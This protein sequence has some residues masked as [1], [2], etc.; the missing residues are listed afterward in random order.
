MDNKKE[1][2]NNVNIYVN[3][4]VGKKPILFRLLIM[5]AIFVFICLLSLSLILIK[6]GVAYASENPY[7]YELI[8]KTDNPDK[9]F[10]FKGE[11]EN[12]YLVFNNLVWRIIRINSSGSIT[13]ML[14]ESLNRLPYS[15]GKDFDILSYLN[16]K[17]LSELDKSKLVS[18]NICFDNITDLSDI[19]CEDTKEYLVTL[20]DINSFVE[21]LQ[22][23]KTY[24]ADDNSMMWLNNSY[25]DKVWHTNGTKL[26]HSSKSAIYDVKPVVTLNYN[27]VSKD[28]NG[29]KNNPY[30]IENTKLTVGSI[31]K[32]EDDEYYVID[33]KDS[34]RLV[35]KEPSE[36]RYSY[37][38]SVESIFSYLNNTYYKELSYKDLLLNVDWDIY[39]IAKNSIK[40]NT[41]K[42]FFG[43][44]SL[45]DFKFNKDDSNYYLATTINDYVLIHDRPMIYGT[46]VSN[47]KIKPCIA[48][49]KDLIGNLELYNGIYV[50]R[51]L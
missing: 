41:F 1:V 19:T 12:N 24:M 36:I 21:S 44:Q 43:I 22:D 4:K 2:N 29:T 32:I 15:I 45:F 46:K 28:G 49:S 16:D 10:V 25:D 26:S 47:H 42:S 6:K 34:I 18:N 14:D 51:D 7:L 8:N 23:E 27:V 13:I 31:V 3:E 30:V 11:A 39:T 9:K 5:N 37:D 40:R 20:P 33:L 48:I 38:G 35:A 50:V 17:F